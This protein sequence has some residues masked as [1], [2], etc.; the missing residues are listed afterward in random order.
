MKNIAIIEDEDPSAELLETYIA[1]YGKEC[2]QHFNVV[3]F[4]N[5]AD[6]LCDYQS[7]YA[8]VF[9]DINMPKMNGMD[10]ATELRKFDKT[11]SIV[12]VTNLM[13]YARRGYEVDAVSFLV[14]PVS[15]YEFSMIYKKA[16]DIYV[17]NGDRGI[18]INLPSGLCRISTDQLMYVEI[19]NHRLYYHLVDDVIEMTGVLSA[20]E[21]ELCGYGF[22][23]CN[24]CYLINPKFV[25]RVKGYEIVVGNQTLQISRPRRVEFLEELADWY[26]GIGS[27]N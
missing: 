17:M 4:E 22:L 2:G 1:K 6:F 9:M 5:A 12:F 19:I 8:V 26:A 7:I 3:R 18:T 21:K 25:V 10:G 23:R 14:K 24:K 27:G 16:L 13:Q 20:V 15:Y 11:V